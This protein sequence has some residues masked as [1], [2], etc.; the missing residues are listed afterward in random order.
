MSGKEVIEILDD[1]WNKYKNNYNNDTIIVSPGTMPDIWHKIKKDINKFYFMKYS[2]KSK[3][4]MSVPYYYDSGKC[5]VTGIYYKKSRKTI[6]VS[7]DVKP[8]DDP[9]CSSW[10]YDGILKKSEL[11]DDSFKETFIKTIKENRLKY[12]NDK[13]DKA[14][15]IIGK[16]SEEIEK[17]EKEL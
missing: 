1:C 8:S 14:L 10:S 7:V 11:L 13:I 9:Y 16:A 6:T 15:V 12:L 2:E 17:I 5:V 3:I 4:G